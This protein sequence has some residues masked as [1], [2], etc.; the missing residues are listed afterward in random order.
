MKKNITRQEINELIQRANALKHDLMSAGM[1]KTY[2]EMDKV[3]KQIGWEA[4]DIISGEHSIA[5]L[6]PSQQ[7]TL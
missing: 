3:T 4:A 7:E 6:L 1:L 5:Q 2:H